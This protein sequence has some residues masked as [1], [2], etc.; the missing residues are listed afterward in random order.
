MF[1]NWINSDL[2]YFNNILDEN[3]EINHKFILDKLKYKT[4]RISEFICLIKQYLMVSYIIGS[5]LYQKCGKF[6]KRNI[7]SKWKMYRSITTLQQIF[8]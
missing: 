7:Y 3:G 1:D 6:S 4:N 2:V 5:N 8:L